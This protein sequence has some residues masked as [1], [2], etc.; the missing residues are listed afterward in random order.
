MPAQ[1]RA[2]RDV[3]CV[4]GSRTVAGQQVTVVGTTRSGV[5]RFGLQRT[6]D[7]AALSPHVF[8]HYPTVDEV[9]AA[10]ANAVG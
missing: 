8:D 2:P 10:L 3:R 7:G 9:A 4:Y 1:N 5:T 6:G